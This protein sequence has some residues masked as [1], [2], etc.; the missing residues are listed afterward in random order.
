MQQQRRQ[1]QQRL[2]QP[3]LRLFFPFLLI[4]LL[5][6]PWHTHSFAS[7]LQCY[8]DL[9]DTEVVMNHQIRRPDE[10]LYAGVEIEVKFIDSDD[11]EWTTTGLQYPAHRPSTVH[12]RL[13]IPP[14]ALD[15]T[16]VQY[17]METTVGG[18]FHPAT[19]CEGSRSHASS[20]QHVLVLNITGEVESVELWAG[21]ATGH[22]AV[23]LTP[24]T[25]LHRQGGVKAEL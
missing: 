12:A 7:W 10:A 6:Q 5:L 17:V 2:Q 3:L 15:Y 25:I 20:R 14:A 8:V 11:S 21:W 22:S 16:D 9:D 19:M 24:R 18:V 1:Q 4:I 23:S 13:R